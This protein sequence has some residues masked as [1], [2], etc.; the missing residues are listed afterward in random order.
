MALGHV[1]F[2]RQFSPYII[3]RHFV[4]IEKSAWQAPFIEERSVLSLIK[5]QAQTGE[6]EFPIAILLL[7]T[8][9]KDHRVRGDKGVVILKYAVQNITSQ[10]FLFCY[11][12]LLHI[13]R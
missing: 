1:R 11:Y 9:G 8:D 12:H 5:Q 6:R 10:L 4:N 7:C 2:I 13:K 3:L